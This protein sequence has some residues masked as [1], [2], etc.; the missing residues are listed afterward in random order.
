[1]VVSDEEI[2]GI[3]S[4]GKLVTVGGLTKADEVEIG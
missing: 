4:G 1:M 3:S 2:F